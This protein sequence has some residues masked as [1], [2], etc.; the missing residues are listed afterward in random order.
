MAFQPYKRSG[1]PTADPDTVLLGHSLISIGPSLFEALGEPE[2][3]Q[4]LF[5]PDKRIVGLQTASEEV[6]GLKV[7]DNRAVT[8][9]G[10]YDAFGIATF[11]KDPMIVIGDN[12]STLKWAA[13]DAVTP[14]N[15]HIRPIYHW[16]REYVR[17]GSID[18]H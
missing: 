15:K 14:K 6:T 13:K 4:L 10:F 18:I 12:I 9:R 17:D 11:V 2:R 1:R 7:R 16:L 8:A 3:V 5:D